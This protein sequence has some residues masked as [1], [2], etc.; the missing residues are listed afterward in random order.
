[1]DLVSWRTKPVCWFSKYGN[2]T[3]LKIAVL[4]AII[5]V[6]NTNA[7]FAG[8]DTTFNTTVTQLTSWT[9]GSLGKLTG[10][11]GVATALIGMVMKF[12][13]RLIAGAAGIGLT[14]ATGPSIVSGLASALF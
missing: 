14:A 10:V 5:G 13:W 9:E 8:T 3:V 2:S 12:D 6:V 4:A 11:A 1:M 7:A